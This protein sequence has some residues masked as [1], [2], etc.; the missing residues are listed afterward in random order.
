[1]SEMRL[2]TARLPAL[3]F[4][5]AGSL[6]LQAATLS[7]AEARY[8]QAHP[9]A[10][11]CVDPDWA[12]FER[13]NEQGRHEGIGADLLQLAA[14]RV[15]LRLQLVPTRSWDESLAASQQGRC[16]LLSFLNQ[17]P[18]RD[19]WLLFTTPLFTDANVFI[20]REEHPFIVDPASLVDASV[21]FPRGTA[22]EEHFRHDY[23]N[24]RVLN[25]GSEAEA[26]ALVS[27][28]KADMTLRSLVMAA[29]TIRNQGWFN[30]KIS[31]E[32]PAY[33]NHLRIGVRK[34]DA[35]LRDILD[36]G[37]RSISAQ[38]RSEIV[39]RHVAVKM[40]RGID[41]WLI[42][43]IVAA[44]AA[45]LL[46][47][48]A[49]NLKLNKLN[50]ELERRSLTDPLTGLANRSLINLQL[51][52]ELARVARNGQP[53]SLLLLDIDHFK[54]V[55]DQFGHQLGD[56]CLQH[57][58]ACLRDSV[59]SSDYLAR[60]GGEEFL[61]LCPGS[62]SQQALLLAER[63]RHTLQQQPAPTGQQQTV[64]IGIASH[65]PG[66][67]ADSLLRRADEAMYRAKHNG[68]DGVVLHQQHRLASS[69]H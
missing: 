28:R 48:A 13:I 16:Q 11:F 7:A 44:C 33:A 24:V 43:K 69:P 46:L 26:L 17:S 3:A 57:V 21:V 62:D 32:L 56:R 42:G 39:N 31:G 8:L 14:R 30:L 65:L 36:K 64:S 66:D 34:Q 41:Y 68:R 54:R 45:L 40:E 60:W 50:R 52:R 10:T 51:P 67:D 5:L 53:L 23:P 29:D 22:M 2:F 27:Q 38:E 1:M 6:P 35:L 47:A 58:A 49:W 12:P 55:N 20:T 25:T 9:V 37:V 19:A 63:I 4:L 61:I 18:K 15:G 59:R